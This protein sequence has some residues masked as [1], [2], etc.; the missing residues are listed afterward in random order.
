MCYCYIIYSEKLT[1]F[2]TGAC[3]D[4]LEQ[5]ILKHNTHAY[6]K[7]R[8]TSNSNDWKLFIKIKT[9]DYAHAIRLERK[10][11]SMKSSHYIKNLKKY[12]EIIS[13]IFKETKKSS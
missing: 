8:F 7:N 1:K 12:P 9:A 6:G 10:I 4:N 2:Y 3:Q 11:K 13:K 5:R